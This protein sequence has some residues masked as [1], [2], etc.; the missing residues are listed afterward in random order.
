MLPTR[1]TVPELCKN[2]NLLIAIIL[3]QLSVL[4]V[5]LVNVSNFD[6]TRLALWSFY[7]QWLVLFNC[8]I[9]CLARKVIHRLPYWLGVLSVCAIY[10]VVL[11]ALEGVIA[12]LL[13]SNQLA[14]QLAWSRVLRMGIAGILVLFILMRAFAVLD[15]LQQRSQSESQARILAL[16]MRINPH[17]LFNSLNTISE[18]TATLPA[19]AEQAIESLSMLFRASLENA[20]TQHTLEQ[21]ITLCQRYL[22]LE[23]WRL[24]DHLQVRWHVTVRNP[25]A[26]RVPKLVLQPLIENAIV[27]GQQDNGDVLVSID[28]RESASHLSLMIDNQVGKQTTHPQ[29]HGI[30]VDNI[31]ER[32]FALYDDQ[33]TFRVKHSDNNYSVLMRIPKNTSTQAA[34]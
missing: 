6:T 21:E 31:R 1:L 7:A 34:L 10:C 18:L 23:Y 2:S 22:D 8:F 9:L 12:Y 16:Q 26:W 3:C 25:A 32:L 5:W 28:C 13:P 4:V 29:G 14:P 30:A 17:F 19:Q 15:V 20:Q 33:Q 11:L 27:H 24:D